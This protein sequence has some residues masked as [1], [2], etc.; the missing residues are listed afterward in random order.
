MPSPKKQ[1][2]DQSPAQAQATRQERERAAAQPEA[3]PPSSFTVRARPGRLRSNGVLR[4]KSSPYGGFVWARRALIGQKRRLFGQTALLGGRGD[5]LD[6][7]AP[8][9][10]EVHHS[11]H[12]SAHHQ[13]Q[14]ARLGP[15]L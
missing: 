6:P 2:F 4:S 10:H 9:A 3:Q 15:F 14:V 11:I 13:G 1:Y 12:G 5:A 7:R 8:R